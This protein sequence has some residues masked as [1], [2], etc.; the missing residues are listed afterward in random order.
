MVARKGGRIM[1]RDEKR[2][3][4]IIRAMAALAANEAGE[5]AKLRRL[6]SMLYWAGALV[7]AGAVAFS[8]DMPGWVAALS[9]AAGGLV[10]GL[11]VHY[12]NSLNQ[13]PTIAPFFDRDGVLRA[14]NEFD[15]S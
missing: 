6:R 7:I 15:E 2:R 11:G 3:R 4:V 14:A 8:G 12:D 1:N 9:A 10:V 13:W 5:L